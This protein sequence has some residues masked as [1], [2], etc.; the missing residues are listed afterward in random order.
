MK[1]KNLRFHFLNFKKL[2]LFQLN[3]AFGVKR[4]RFLL[5]SI[6]L[7]SFTTLQLRSLEGEKRQVVKDLNELFKRQ[8]E[9]MEIQ[10][11]QHFQVR[12]YLQFILF[13]K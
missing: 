9:E 5:W 4:G 1:T 11:L 12:S 10:Q 2:F 6:L 7:N 8:K 3:A 13:D